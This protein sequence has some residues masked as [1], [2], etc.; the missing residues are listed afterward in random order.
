MFK[1]NS[2]NHEYNI[3]HASD[4]EYPNNKLE[5]GNKSICYQGIK[6]WNNIKNSRNLHAF[7]SSFKD[8]LISHYINIE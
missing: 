1:I 6:S 3:P 5:F 2:E 7:K 8:S 4:F